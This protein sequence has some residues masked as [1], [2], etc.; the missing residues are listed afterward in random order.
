[1]IYPPMPFK[2]FGDSARKKERYARVFPIA[3]P[4]ALLWQGLHY[5]LLGRHQRVNTLWKSGITQAEQLGMVYEEGLA[6]YE[7]ACQGVTGDLTTCLHLRPNEFL[8]I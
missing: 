8:P 2:F 5:W 6:H 4:R 7:F 1:M 3:K